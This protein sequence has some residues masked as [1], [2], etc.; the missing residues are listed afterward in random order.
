[1][2]LATRVLF[3]ELETNGKQHFKKRSEFGTVRLCCVV[4]L[5]ANFAACMYSLLSP[6]DPTY[7]CI[8]LLV[9]SV[10]VDL[11]SSPSF[12]GSLDLLWPLGLTHSQPPATTAF[13]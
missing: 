12:E 1:M 7:R 9:S 5:K 3:L 6:L 4:S 13:S 11:Y 8:Q 2:I 10:A